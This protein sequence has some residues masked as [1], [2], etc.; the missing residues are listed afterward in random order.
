M[1]GLHP[2]KLDA[3]SWRAEVEVVAGDVLDMESLAAAFSEI[4]AA[5]TGV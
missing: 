5:L 1:P 4:D 2:D 3:E